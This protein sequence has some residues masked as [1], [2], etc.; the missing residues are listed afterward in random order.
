MID[1]KL[2]G[3]YYRAILQIIYLRVNKTI[4]IR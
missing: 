3:E 2:N 4:G 1:V